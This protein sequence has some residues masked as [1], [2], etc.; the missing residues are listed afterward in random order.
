MP[1][2]NEIHVAVALIINSE[3]QVLT[4][5]RADHQHQGG[6][7]EFP[8]GKVEANESV[9]VALKREVY[10]E[11][12]LTIKKCI[13]FKS[14]RHDYGDRKVLLDVWQIDQFSGDAHGRE[15]QEIKWQSI[16]SLKP[17]DFPK[18]NQGLIRCLQLPDQLLITG[19]YGD[20]DD[21]LERLQNALQQGIRLVQLR[22]KN[23][24]MLEL[25]QLSQ[26]AYPL[27]RSFNALLLINTDLQGFEDCQSDGLHLTSQ[28]LFSMSERPFDEK[29][30]LSASCHTPDDILQAK[31]LKADFI[32]LSPVKETSSHPGVKGIGWQ[33]FS[34]MLSN[35]DMPVYAL[36]GMSPSDLADAKSHGAQGIAAISSFW[37]RSK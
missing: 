10:E 34:D 19:S 5:L 26:M 27:C 36:G 18:A 13:P 12:G 25:Q 23:L 32:L 15:G 29:Y 33:R 16:D 24:S 9:E 30:F 7:W 11:L 35:I 1:D 8:G 4:A 3:R 2:C 21:F 14:I 31:K 22:S 28:Q 6:L 37:S 20:Q 17:G